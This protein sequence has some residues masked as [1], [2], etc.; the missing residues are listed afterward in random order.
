M[1]GRKGALTLEKIN[2]TVQYSAKR[3]EGATELKLGRCRGGETT[4]VMA[5]HGFNN[6]LSAGQKMQGFIK[7]PPETERHRGGI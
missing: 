4:T 5:G 3:G 7:R 2:G 6:I 1:G